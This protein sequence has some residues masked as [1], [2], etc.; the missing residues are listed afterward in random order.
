[1]TK[2]QKKIVE[3]RIK[4]MSKN[5]PLLSNI[6]DKVITNSDYPIL[7]DFNEKTGEMRII[8]VGFSGME[9]WKKKKANKQKKLNKDEPVSPFTFQDEVLN[10]FKK[11]K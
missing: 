8:V 1:M 4:R 3:A 9:K 10:L 11:K 5:I 7:Y 6:I 2:N